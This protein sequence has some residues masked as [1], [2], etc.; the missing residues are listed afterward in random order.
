MFLRQALCAAIICVGLHRASAAD[1]PNNPQRPNVL[2][3]LADDLGWSDVGAFGSEIRTP[4]IDDLAANGRIFTQFYNTARCCPSRASL[5]TGLY[6]HQAG[7]GHM[8]WPTGYPGYSTRLSNDCV[9]IAEVLREAGYRTYMTGKWHLSERNPSPKDTTGWPLARGFDEF[10]GTLAGYGSFYDPATLARSNKFITPENDPDYKPPSY[11]YTD[12]ISDNSVAFLQQHR[13]QHADRPFFMYVAYTAAHWPIQVPEDSLAEYH[14]KYDAG[15]DAIRQARIAK[16]KRQGLY[17]G[18]QTPAPTTGDWDAVKDKAYEARRME[19]FAAMITRM[20]AG[21]GKIV[22][23]LKATGQLDDT[24]ILYMHDN[25]GCDEEFFHGNQQPPDNLHAMRADELQSR[26]LPPMQTR[27]GHVVRTGAGVM[28]GPPE[29]FVGY[30]PGWANVS[31]TPLRL[32]KKN[33][34]EGGVSTPLVVHWPRGLDRKSKTPIAKPAHLIDVMP[35][36]LEVTGAAYPQRFRG[37]AIQPMAGVSLAPLLTGDGEFSRESPIFWEHEGNRAVR[38]DN[39]KL[40]S[41]ENSPWELY[42]IDQDRG[43]M[44]NLAE[45]HP[46]KVEQLAKHWD[47]YIQ[48]ARVEPYG[49][50][51]LRQ[52]AADPPNAPQR[53]ELGSSDTV[54]RAAGLALSD[55]GLKITA[56]IRSDKSH[57]VIVAQGASQHGFSL[58]LR[59]G[60]VHFA[61]RRAGELKTLSTPAPND[62]GPATVVAELTRHG[63]ARLQVGDQPA[64]TAAFYGPLLATPEGPLSVSRDDANP[65]GK[66]PKDFPF[67]GTIE[68]VTV[69]AIR[70]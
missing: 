63:Q 68:S 70:P 41:L 19:A 7:V 29:S 12:A 32:V 39:W 2:V 47:E 13:Q 24:L 51:R 55:A 37:Q 35:T 22:S 36:V 1:A 5:L 31:N 20:D 67:E 18:F 10:Y 59:K 3:I 9:T 58:Y 27:D 8:L 40:V 25:G 50:H 4:N 11:Y 52:R 33:T 17:D 38:L 16:L 43:E 21:I 66:Y 6:P 49:A 30:G 15:Y 64:A 53:L 54:E 26:T 42:D 28:A 48:R 56:R 61:I 60:R 69:E 57:G 62:A 46:E 45:Q 23:H 34:H 14:G 65:V 44:H